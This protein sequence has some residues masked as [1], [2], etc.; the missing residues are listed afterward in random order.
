M[1]DLCAKKLHSED[2]G[3]LTDLPN[4]AQDALLTFWGLCL[5]NACRG[6]LDGWLSE[7]KEKEEDNES[8]KA[9]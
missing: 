7:I 1:V 5:K 8:Q 6:D 2:V 3:D 9:G 4:S